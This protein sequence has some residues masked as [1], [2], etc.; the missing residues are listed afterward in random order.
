VVYN[1]DSGVGRGLVGLRLGLMDRMSGQR[2][3]ERQLFVDCGSLIAFVPPDMR[4]GRHA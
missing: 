4:P 1:G 2:M 3:V